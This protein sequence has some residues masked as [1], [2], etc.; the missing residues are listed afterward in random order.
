MAS[1]AA[2][3]E[4]LRTVLFVVVFM[5]FPPNVKGSIRFDPAVEMG[6]KVSW[7]ILP[8]GVELHSTGQFLGKGKDIENM[9]APCS[10][11]SVQPKHKYSGNA[12]NS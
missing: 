6:G 3:T 9:I 12:N 11:I 1:T 8:P 5:I 10:I 4:L 7:F 2:A